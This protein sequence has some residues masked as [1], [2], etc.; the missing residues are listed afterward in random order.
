MPP[1]SSGVSGRPYLDR[2]EE[3]RESKGGKKGKEKEQGG[4]KEGREK[5]SQADNQTK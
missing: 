4:G 3:K 5:R 2:E 1:D